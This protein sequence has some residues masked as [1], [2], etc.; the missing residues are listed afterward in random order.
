M[1]ESYGA[2][3]RS[4][5]SMSKAKQAFEVK[6]PKDLLE[7]SMK[8]KVLVYALDSNTI[9]ISRKK[10]DEWDEK[11]LWKGETELQEQNNHFLLILP[12]QLV[13]FYKTFKPNYK[14]SVYK[15]GKVHVFFEP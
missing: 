3:A 4:S 12:R 13:S 2:L 9:G 6:I 10:S 7:Q 14:V 1:T 11:A 15:S 5:A 8:G